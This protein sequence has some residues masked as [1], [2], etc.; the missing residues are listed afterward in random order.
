MVG[1]AAAMAPIT[2]STQS[3]TKLKAFQY[4][5]K[6]GQSDGRT[7]EGEKENVPFD[8]VAKLS[9]NIPPPPSSS[10][11]SNTKDVRDCPQTPLGRLPLSELLASGEDKRQNL[12]VTPIERVLW[13]NSTRSSDLSV[14]AAARKGRK[15]AHSSSPASS[16]Q[17]ETSDPFKEQDKLARLHASQSAFKTPK[18]DPIDDLWSHYSMNT[19]PVELRSPTAGAGVA[20]AL[21]MPSSSPQTPANHVQRDANGL[22]RALS[23]IEWP[24]SAAKRRKLFHNSSQTKSAIV[25]DNAE[26]RGRPVESSKMSR[27]NLLL[28]KVHSGLVRSPAPDNEFS[29]SEP[30]RSS[31]AAKQNG[32][33][34]PVQSDDASSGNESQGLVDNAARVLGQNGVALQKE[35]SA[36]LV[37]SKEEIANLENANSSDFDDDELDLEMLENIQTSFDS[38]ESAAQEAAKQNHSYGWSGASLVTEIKDR[39]PEEEKTWQFR[40]TVTKEGNACRDVFAPPKEPS[41]TAKELSPDHDDFGEDDNETFAA[42]LED[43]CAKYDSQVQKSV[44]RENLEHAHKDAGAD[45]VRSSKSPTLETRALLH[46]VA[47]SDIEVSS[48][49]DDFGDD[50]DFEQIAVECAEAT[51]KQQIFQPQ[52]SVRTLEPS[53]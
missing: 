9:Q 44:G 33:L 3:R 41:L 24:T 17:N 19:G 26:P 28:E 16:S 47:K 14:A 35:A 42:D 46:G 38:S 22:R 51:Q 21:S 48:D 39:P 6:D 20:L 32:I 49:D 8:T 5:R 29:S 25:K 13:D 1:S 27:V 23:C 45:R 2:A 53:V 37:L 7:L 18:L 36:P 43:V 30:S 50:L 4:E 34:P 10:Q 40:P 52:L 11:K 12:N 31:P 15:R